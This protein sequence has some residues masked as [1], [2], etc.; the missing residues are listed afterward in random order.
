[1]LIGV[2]IGSA[3]GIEKIATD[4]DFD[5]DSDPELN[6]PNKPN[7]LIN[8]NLEA[9]NATYVHYIYIDIYILKDYDGEKWVFRSVFKQRLL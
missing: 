1:M 7:K 4:P 2:G 8:A 3:I 5:P 9:R 6:K